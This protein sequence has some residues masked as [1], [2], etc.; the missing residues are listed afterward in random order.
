MRPRTRRLPERT[1]SRKGCHPDAHAGRLSADEGQPEV[2][3]KKD[4]S[5]Q[6]FADLAGKTVATVNLQGLFHLGVAYAVEKAGKDPN[7]IKALAMA[8]IDEANAIAANRIDAAVMQDPFLSQA[9]ATGQF[10]SLGNPFSTFPYRIPVGAFWSSKS[11]I[12]SKPGLLRTFIAAW[13]EAVTTAMARPKLTK[14]I[15]P[16]YTGISGDVAKLITVPEYITSMPAKA[17][18]PMLVTMKKY[19]WIK[20]IPSYN[21]IVWNGK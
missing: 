17:L 18:G 9:K 2:L 8:P 15:I 14:Q 7:S 19:G 4:S 11:T 6:N 13:K 5:I 20:I 21:E 12:G 16:K 1:R 10:R 3:V